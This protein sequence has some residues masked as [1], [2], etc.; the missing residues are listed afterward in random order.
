MFDFIAFDTETT[1]VSVYTDRIIEVAAVKF[2]K[3]KAVSY[4]HSLVNPEINIPASAQRVHGI[5]NEMVADAPLIDDVIEKFTSF[6][7]K[8][9]LVAHNSAFD[10]RFITEAG[11]K[12]SIPLPAGKIFDT[13]QMAKRVLPELMN[14]KLESLTKHYKLATDKFHRAEDDANYCGRIFMHLMLEI[15]RKKGSCLIKDLVEFSGKELAFPFIESK[16]KQL[17]LFKLSA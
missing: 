12:H 9:H 2:S 4:F 1:G 8:A 16:P 11:K 14:H 17:N 10:V 15:Q 7:A 5:S 6:S 3:G 13:Y